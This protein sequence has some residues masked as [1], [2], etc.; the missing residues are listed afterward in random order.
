MGKHTRVHLHETKQLRHE[1]NLQLVCDITVKTQGVALLF[2]V[3]KGSGMVVG[4][5]WV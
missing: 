4:H 2:T 1:I 5:D 3:G